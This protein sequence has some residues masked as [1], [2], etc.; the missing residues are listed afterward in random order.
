MTRMF[1]I[2]CVAVLVLCQTNVGRAA[3]P[4]FEAAIDGFDLRTQCGSFKGSNFS[5]E[6]SGTG[7]TLFAQGQHLLHL[8]RN[9]SELAEARAATACPTPIIVRPAPTSCCGVR[10]CYGTGT[11]SC[12]GVRTTSSCCGGSAATSTTV[13]LAPIFLQAMTPPAGRPYWCNCPD[14]IRA[15]AALGR[16]DWQ[17][18]PCQCRS[19]CARC[20]MHPH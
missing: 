5:V 11:R 8:Q 6:A 20:A 2:V 7:T 13:G 18:I 4:T 14:H 12:C 15:C 10:S 16:T 17:Y 3:D 19:G 1:A 9:A